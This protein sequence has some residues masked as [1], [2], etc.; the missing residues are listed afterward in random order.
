MCRWDTNGVA[1]ELLQTGKHEQEEI[2]QVL[3][4]LAQLHTLY[5]DFDIVDGGANVGCWT[6]QLS[7]AAPWGTVYSFEPQ[8][9]LYHA[10]VGNVALNNCHNVIPCLAAL[11]ETPRQVSVVQLPVDSPQ[12]YSTMQLENQA[13][14]ADVPREI[15]A[16]ITIDSL[17][18]PIKLM[19]LDVEGMEVK[20]IQGAEETIRIW[21]PVIFAEVWM[22]GSLLP[23]LPQYKETLVSFDKRNAIYEPEEINVSL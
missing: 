3:K 21:R 18:K 2:D 11:T 20:A 9:R 8:R 15:V 14:P 22:S 19:K 6:V 10:L 16:G 17:R 7:K 23:L 4:I 5:G 12:Q 13:V 1:N